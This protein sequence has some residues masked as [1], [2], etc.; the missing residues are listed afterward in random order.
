MSTSAYF[1]DTGKPDLDEDLLI[2]YGIKGM[3]WGVR[4]GDHPGASR[5]T[6]REAKKDAHEF[7]RA[8]L[9][10]GEGA[11]TRRKLIKASVE[12]KAKR[13]P[14]YKDAF[15]HHLAGQDLGEHAQK[16]RAERRHKD[17]RANVRKTGNSINRALNGPFAG[18]AAIALVG[19]GA[20]YAKNVGLDKKASDV[21]RKAANN[22]NIQR[23]V[24]DILRNAAAGR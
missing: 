6:N 9:F 23:Q 3:K 12:A 20:A 2:H 4:K 10:Y 13:D 8:K 14:S 7:A 19:A 18:S 5:K 21:L 15:D 22:R 24:Q 16:A 17:T 11:G 1:I